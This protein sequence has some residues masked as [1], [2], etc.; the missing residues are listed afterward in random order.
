MRQHIQSAIKLRQEEC[1]VQLNRTAHWRA[2]VAAWSRIQAM[3]HDA[4][5]AG[6]LR[7]DPSLAHLQVLIKTAITT[8]TKILV[9]SEKAAA[10]G[11]QTVSGNRGQSVAGPVLRDGGLGGP[12]PTDLEEGL[13]V[14][15]RGAHISARQLQQ[16]LWRPRD[17]TKLRRLKTTLRSK[18]AWQ[19][20]R[21]E[22]LR[23]PSC[24]L[25]VAV[26]PGSTC[27]ERPGSLCLWSQCARDTHRSETR[28]TADAT[29]GHHA[30][31]KALSGVKLA[32]PAITA[33]PRRLSDSTS[34]ASSHFPCRRCHRR[35]RGRQC[36]RI[37][38]KR[39]SST[40]RCRSGCF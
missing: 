26:S 10:A 37:V 6:V 16:Q 20:A 1:C 32:D 25:Q 19:R 15:A 34:N 27:W 13:V 8:F 3:M 24:L 12:L 22:G 36:L 4:S 5:N 38:L 9:D 17:R 29:R 39:S 21:I 18:G 7:A 2:P 31:V 30:C 33:E 35:W 14:M 40:W 11:Q 23:G 28:S